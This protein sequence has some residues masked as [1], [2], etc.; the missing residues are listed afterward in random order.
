M[1][2][3]GKIVMVSI[4]VMLAFIGVASAIPFTTLPGDPGTVK[5]DDARIIGFDDGDSVFYIDPVSLTW[6]DGEQFFD[7]PAGRIWI[8]A[9]T[10][11]MGQYFNWRTETWAPEVIL[12]KGGPAAN[13]YN[14][15]T[16]ADA[17]PG[18]A[19]TME[20]FGLHAPDNP[21][22]PNGIWYGISHIDFCGG[23]PTPEFPTIA[24]PVGMI[25]GFLGIVSLVRGKKE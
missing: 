10:E 7:T 9:K 15:I 20:D 23:V 25:I 13:V 1:K 11:A 18:V 17:T 5:C 16:Y 4:L 14:Y 21:D 3:Y 22:N 6:D 8:D 19:D 2:K 24:L 12:V